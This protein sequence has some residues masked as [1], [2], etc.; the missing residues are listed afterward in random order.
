VDPRLLECLRGKPPAARL[1]LL[2]VARVIQKRGL[3]LRSRLAALVRYLD[4]RAPE[5]RV[6]VA[7]LEGAGLVELI[8]PGFQRRGLRYL[9]IGNAEPI[10]VDPQLATNDHEG[11][12][13][14]ILSGLDGWI[15]HSC[16]LRRVSPQGIRARELADVVW[17]AR[18]YGLVE[19]IRTPRGG[20]AYKWVGPGPAAAVPPVVI[21]A[22]ARRRV[23]RV[24]QREAARLLGQRDAELQ[25]R[26]GR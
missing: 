11:R 10:E 3:V 24:A 16:L 5:L 17:K 9:W 23:L 8:G 18:R 12:V 2:T 1:R 4:L 6:I 21:D 14:G 22:A 13:V 26:P 15:H 7:E 25:A 19:M 20:R